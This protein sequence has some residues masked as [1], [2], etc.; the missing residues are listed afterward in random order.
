MKRSSNDRYTYRVTWSEE[1]KEFVGL[2]AEFPSLSWLAPSPEAALRGIRTVVAEAVKDI[3]AGGEP[4]PEPLSARHFSGKFMIRV[5]PRNPSA[6]GHRGGRRRRQSESLGQRQ[7][8]A[9][10]VG[11]TFDPCPKLPQL[12][13]E[14]LVAAIEVVDVVDDRA[15]FGGQAG[16]NQRGAGAEV[17]RRST[18]A[19][20]RRATPVTMAVS[21]CCT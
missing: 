6:A 20:L 15:A 14:P 17:S 19:P 2:C 21:P 11:R 4:I 7:V 10:I 8:V 9:I 5:P 12:V 13:V 16:Q 3:R 1:D 18:R